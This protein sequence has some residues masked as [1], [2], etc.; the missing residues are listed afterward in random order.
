M[1]LLLVSGVACAYAT[2]VVGTHR[3]G[4]ARRRRAAHGYPTL[5]WLDWG[6]LLGGLAAGVGPEEALSVRP[7]DGGPAV[8]IPDDPA[9]PGRREL[10]AAL[11]QGQGVGDDRWTTVGFSESEARWLATLAL[12]QRDPPAALER[13]ERAGADTAPAVYL[14]EHLAVQLEPGPFS[15]ELAVFRVKRRLAQALHRFDTAPELY[16]ARARASACLGLTEAVLDDLARAVY[17]SRERPF[18]LRA[19]VGLQVAS[20]LRPALW[21]QCAQSLSRREVFQVN[22]GPGHA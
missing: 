8:S 22:M 15:L 9:R 21:Q 1:S 17:F 10:L 7:A 18:F 2:A 3:L 20:D 4:V 13:L 19:V 16:F 14:R 11:A 6:A 5:A 12:A